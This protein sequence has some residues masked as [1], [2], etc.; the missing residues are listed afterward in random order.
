MYNY[1]IYHHINHGLDHLPIIDY[2]EGMQ[3][4][5]AESMRA[6]SAHSKSFLCYQQGRT[7]RKWYNTKNVGQNHLQR[8]QARPVEYIKKGRALEALHLAAEVITGSWT[9]AVALDKVY[10]N[11]SCI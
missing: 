11:Y 1:S 10:S 5:F 6:T 4:A 8:V 9:D 7:R 3:P 2:F